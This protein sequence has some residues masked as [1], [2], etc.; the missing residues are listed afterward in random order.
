MAMAEVDRE[1]A[2]ARTFVR[3]A[4]T[5]VSGCDLVELYDDL[6]RSAVKLF[7]L[8]AAGVVLADQRGELH[9]M[10]SSSEE[11]RQIEVFELQND[12]GP[13]MDAYKT[14][15]PVAAIHPE[16]QAARWPLIAQRITE[17][18]LG[19]A[20]AVPMRLRDETI[21]A[22]NF[23][24]PPAEPLPEG[25][26]ETAH[27]MADVATIAVLHYRS[28]QANHELAAQLQ[29]AL[30]SRVMIE[31][32]KGVL[33]ERGQVDMDVAFALLRAYARSTNSHL[34]AVAEAI[35]SGR[36]DAGLPLEG[37]QAKPPDA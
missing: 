6:V 36:L 5:L 32:A 30:D 31:Q 9:V 20:Y 7:G 21:G 28:A 4:A 33:A 35:A 27:A 23:F 16:E 2:L 24:R 1:H 37:L 3:L 29:G 15:Q 14:G 18:G 8:R 10:A 11:A 22:V 25:D 12:Q 34:S 26:L 19:P 13:C 17:V